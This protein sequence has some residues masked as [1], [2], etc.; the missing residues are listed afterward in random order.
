[1]TKDLTQGNVLKRIVGFAF[2]VFLASLLQQLYN[3]ADSIIVGRFVGK[4]AF[5]AVGAT[6][7]INF[8]IIGFVL[9]TCTGLTIPVAQRF[10]AG[11]YKE[12]RKEL[13]TGIYVAGIL[14]LVLTVVTTAGTGGLLHLMKTP[15][16]IYKDAYTY[17]FIIFLGIPATVLYNMPANISRALGDSRTP[18]YFLML[19]AG[20]NVVLDLVFVCIF[21]MGVAGT[22]TATVIAQVLS[23]VFCIL[24]MKKKYTVLKLEK[25]EW[26]F[27]KKRALR[28]TGM[29]VPM[30]LQFSITAIG[31]VILQSAVNTMGSD[32]VAAVNA[33][34]KIQMIMVQPMD[35][36]GVTMA[37]FA[38]QNLGS[39]NIE[40]IRKGVRVAVL[41]CTVSAVIGFAGSNLLCL[42]MTSLF[43]RAEEMN[44]EIRSCITQ[45][46]FINS[47]F[48]IPLGSLGVLR[49]ALQG[50]GHSVAAMGSGL[51]EMFGRTIVAFAATAYFGFDA[52]C[53]S[54]PTAWIMANLILIPMY[55][56][57]I[58]KITVS[59]GTCAPVKGT[60]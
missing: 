15:D 34:M 59:Y 2:P 8:L 14:A 6:G 53:Y 32:T 29:S 50:L 25:D 49:N 22:A 5:A 30:G 1:M 47:I 21:H 33:A 27:E 4:D 18:L 11:D 3:M 41:A 60:V 24:Y 10:G 16:N 28:S 46:L 23:G 39:G 36:L 57:V 44:D 54:N 58:R 35:A 37:T 19:S 12:M 31:S 42:P 38:G 45:L 43:I 9:G 26:V 55:Y 17:I 13:A 40:R 20:I 56:S 52:I 7:S 48:Y 51:F